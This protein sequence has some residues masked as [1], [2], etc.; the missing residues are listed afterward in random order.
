MTIL[1]AYSIMYKLHTLSKMLKLVQTYVQACSQKCCS[2]H[3]TNIYTH[4]SPREL[5]IHCDYIDLIIIA[6]C[7]QN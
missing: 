3:T 4:A 7:V 2:A 1:L 6:I 5:Y